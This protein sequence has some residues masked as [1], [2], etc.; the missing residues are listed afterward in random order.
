MGR[1]GILTRFTPGPAWIAGRPF[2]EQPGYPRQIRWWMSLRRRGV[3]S[4][5]GIPVRH[6]EQL[7]VRW[8]V[9]RLG[10]ARRLAASAPFVRRGVL[11]EVTLLTASRA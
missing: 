11:R 9:T 10:E 4:W 7:F 6:P 8:H 1:E 5:A 3:L 2:E